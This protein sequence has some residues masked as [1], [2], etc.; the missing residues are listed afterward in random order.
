MYGTCARCNSYGLHS[1]GI[2]LNLQRCAPNKL[3]LDSK[4]INERCIYLCRQ[5]SLQRFDPTKG[6]GKWKPER[7]K[8]RPMTKKRKTHSSQNSMSDL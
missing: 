7:R 6:K 4:E 3:N 1:N 5:D 8:E 2:Y